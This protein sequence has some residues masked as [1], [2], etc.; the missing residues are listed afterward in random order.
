MSAP[1]HK[2]LWLLLLG[3]LAPGSRAAEPVPEAQ[4][5]E[6]LERQLREM[7]K[8]PAPE[9]VVSFEGLPKPEGYKL[10]EAEFLLDNEP[11]VTPA[12]EELNG[13]GSHRLAVLQVAEG[14]HTLVSRV[15]YV[16]DSWSLF[17]ETS[18][19]L[20]K[21]TG[22]VNFQAQRGL[23]VRA[24]VVP[25]IVPNAPDPRL[26]IKLTHDVSAEMTAPLA[27][28][29]PTP[30]PA[31]GSI[32]DAGTPPPLEQG[33]KPEVVQASGTPG[34]SAAQAGAQVPAGAARLL[35][36]VTAFKKPVGATVRLRGA[37]ALKQLD[38][39]R[40][41][42]KPTRLE[43][44]PGAYT[45]EVVAPGYL[46]QVRKVS[47]TQKKGSALAFAL[48]RAPVKKWQQLRVKDSR[49]ELPVLPGFAEKRSVPRKGST[50]GVPQLVDLLVRDGAVRLRIEGHTDS[51][52][53]TDA[54]R[55]TLSLA[56]A[57]A[58]ADLLM[59]AGV[60]ASRIEVAGYADSRPKAPNLTTRG[61]QLNRRVEF[62]L[63][64]K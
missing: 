46:A 62:T 4:V 64:R 42:R 56:R 7:V 48:L 47:L 25:A 32:P 10:L 43:V 49:I 29:T 54:N 13:P 52:E 20:W 60:D 2:A 61:R 59:K 30:E 11:L 8:T 16:N 15:T 24:K 36:K 40:K 44:A 45:V 27:D 28:A 37:G 9:V 17:S 58:V 39:D 23:R 53:G 38:L 12:P 35:L 21:M 14:T 19:R 33:T 63:L 18:G 34:A 50:A 3:L 22:T 41:S 57:R 51:R 5:R 6:D 31:P 1:S 55:Q 26:K